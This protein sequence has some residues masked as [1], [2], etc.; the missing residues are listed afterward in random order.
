MEI[1]FILKMLTDHHSRGK[2]SPK[3]LAFYVRVLV[4]MWGTG[5]TLIFGP[6]TR[7]SKACQGGLSF[8][9]EIWYRKRL[10]HTSSMRTKTGGRI[11]EYWKFM[12]KIWGIKFANYPLSIIVMKTNLKTLPKIASLAG[13]WA[14]IFYQRMKRLLAYAVISIVSVQDVG[15][16]K[17]RSSML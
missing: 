4:R 17:K 5:G 3:H 6:I 11:T 7:G 12:V 2:A 10:C 8:W 9:I 13:E 16:I 1:S 14:M 15:M